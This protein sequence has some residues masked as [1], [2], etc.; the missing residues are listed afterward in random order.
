MKSVYAL[1][2]VVACIVAMPVFADDIPNGYQLQLDALL[3]MYVDVGVQGIFYSLLAAGAIQIGL[4]WTSWA[5]R[6]VGSFFGR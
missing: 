1:I 2:F 4:G 3:S 6:S 5:T